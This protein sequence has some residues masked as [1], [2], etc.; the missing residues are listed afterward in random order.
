M[1]PFARPRIPSVPKYL[2][3]M[4]GGPTRFPYLNRDI[5]RIL[6]GRLKNIG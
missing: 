1:M 3:T 4:I 5:S 2:R 6:G